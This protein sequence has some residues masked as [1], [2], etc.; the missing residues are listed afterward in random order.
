MADI[1]VA[2]F[3]DEAAVDG[4]RAEFDVHFDPTL[5]D[6]PDDLMAAARTARALI[7]RNRTQVRGRLLDA[8][9]RLECVGRL[10]VGLD[11]IDVAAC[12]RRNIEV[13]PATGA[14]VVAVAEYVVT[15]ALVLLRGAWLSSADVA[16]GAWPRHDLTG[17]EVSGKIIGLVGFGAIGQAVAT[18]AGALGMAVQ[19]CDPHLE[20]GHTAWR[21]ARKTELQRLLQ[22]SDVISLHVQLSDDTRDLIG[23]G[24]I[25]SMKPG[26]I[27]INTARG[28]VVDE[29]ALAAALADGRLGGAA[30]DVFCDEPLT[31]AG[32]AAFAGLKNVVLT[33]HIAGV[34]E[35]SNVRVSRL[36]AERVGEHLLMSCGKD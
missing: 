20:D 24:A 26:A 7:V 2:E 22:T 36:I 14:N 34:T 13:I 8:M 27:V 19:A 23:H 31:A 16:A 17:R 35:E 11:N 18:R 3:M 25:A 21:L 32:G 30:L 10:G 33:P 1:V 4:L 5:V 9:E 15:A 28:G 12:R 6:R 29:V